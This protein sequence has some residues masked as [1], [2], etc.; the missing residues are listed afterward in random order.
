[1]NLRR[2]GDVYFRQSR[3]FLIGM[4]RRIDV[5]QVSSDLLSIER[6]L[7]VLVRLLLRLAEHR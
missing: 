6:H 3:S 1:M 5:V 4:L 7:A 2:E